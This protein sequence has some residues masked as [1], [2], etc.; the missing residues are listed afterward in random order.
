M[1][2]TQT[3]TQVPNDFL[4]RLGSQLPLCNQAPPEK[5]AM[6]VIGLLMVVIGI[7]GGLYVM[8]TKFWSKSEEE[9]ATE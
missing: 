6:C 4:T 7:I 1:A 8:Y 9:E 3:Q 5:R 2:E